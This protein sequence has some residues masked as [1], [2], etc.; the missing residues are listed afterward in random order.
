[1][2]IPSLCLPLLVYMRRLLTVA[3][4]DLY[5]T[6]Y[7]RASH[8]HVFLQACSLQILRISSRRLV[9]ALAGINNYTVHYVSTTLFSESSIHRCI[10][11]T[12]SSKLVLAEVSCSWRV[13][14]TD[15]A[16]MCGFQ[17]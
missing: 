12:D 3:A 2:S 7:R 4:T 13:C 14:I 10:C 17:D 6:T 16:P 8:R 5:N 1:M 15:A 11:H 9:H